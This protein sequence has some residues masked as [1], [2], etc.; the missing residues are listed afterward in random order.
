MVANGSV[1]AWECFAETTV[2]VIEGLKGVVPPATGLRWSRCNVFAT[3]TQSLE[4]S[5]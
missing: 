2:V 4:M 5:E 1:L 3:I